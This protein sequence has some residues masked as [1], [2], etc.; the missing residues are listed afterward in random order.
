M[1]SRHTEADILAARKLIASSA[2]WVEA[3]PDQ[4]RP[5]PSRH[6]IHPLCAL[7][8]PRRDGPQGALRLPLMLASEGR[9]PVLP[10]GSS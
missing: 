8:L 2:L 9:S 6:P 7:T 4:T 3:Y 10:I 1:A 5:L